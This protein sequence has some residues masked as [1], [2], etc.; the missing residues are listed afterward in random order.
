[1]NHTTNQPPRSCWLR[2]LLLLSPPVTQLAHIAHACR[3]AKC[4][5]TYGLTPKGTCAQVTALLRGFGTA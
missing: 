2:S 3:C 5:D 4:F 1:M